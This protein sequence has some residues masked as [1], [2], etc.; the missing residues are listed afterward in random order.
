MK[1]VSA[2]KDSELLAMRAAR[3]PAA[4]G[5]V[6]WRFEASERL[7][8]KPALALAA[9]FALAVPAAAQQGPRTARVQFAPGASAKAVSGSIKGYGAVDY[10]VSAKAGQTL[11][12]KLKTSNASNYF[13]VTGPGADAAL[14]VGSTSGGDYSGVLPASGDYK[15]SVYLMRNAARRGESAKYTLTVAV[16]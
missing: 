16:K 5:G 13:N 9:L 14:F 12:V 6:D 8:R 10:L 7:M 4:G 11:S 1:P 2:P 3:F 15:V